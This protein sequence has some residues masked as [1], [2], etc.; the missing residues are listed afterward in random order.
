[1]YKVG[2][3]MS[4]KKWKDRRDAKRIKMPAMM[5]LLTYLTDRQ[6]ADVYINRKLDVTNLVKY[7]S[8][9]KKEISDLTYFHAFSIAIAKIIYNR[10][11]LNRYIINHKCYERNDVILTFVAKVDFSD[12]AKEVMTL[13]KVKENDNIFTISDKIKEKVNSFRNKKEQ[14]NTDDSLDALDK[15][16]GWMLKFFVAPIVK[17]MDRH[18]LLPNSLNNDLIYNSTVIMSNLGS[19]KCGAIYHHLTNFGTNGIIVTI[20]NIHKEVVVMPNGK[21]E[22][23]DIVEFGITLDE[24]IADGVYFAKAINLLDYIFSHPETLEENANTIIEE[25]KDF[26]Y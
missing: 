25:K 22:I 14:N 5:R 7:M 17:F 13:I 3:D 6:D 21:Q 19:I 12:N 18:D 15:L 8:S 4:K 24:R 20:G 26:E 23:R 11:K 16:P 10:P 9:K 1:M 2:G